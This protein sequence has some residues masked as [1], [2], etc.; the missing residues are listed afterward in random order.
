L[1]M[2]SLSAAELKFL[3]ALLG[4]AD[5]CG[6]LAELGIERQTAAVVRLC[7]ALAQKGL[8]AYEQEIARFAIARA[9]KT[10]LALDTTSLP[11]TPDELKVLKACKGSMTP[12]QLPRHIPTSAR[13]SLISNL[14]HRSLIKVTR[15]VITSVWITRQG[16]QFLRD[17]YEPS[18]QQSM[19]SARLVANYIRFLRSTLKP[20]VGE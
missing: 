1:V 6:S 10:L 12:A 4:Q 5:Y 18:G 11:V 20:S 16:Q 19:G 15:S 9:G 3:M 17:D 8:V 14:A 2:A 7:E 13:Q